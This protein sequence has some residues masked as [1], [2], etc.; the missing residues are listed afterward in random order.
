MRGHGIRLRII[1]HD[2]LCPISPNTRRARSGTHAR[3]YALAAAPRLLASLHCTN[4]NS[5]RRSTVRCATQHRRPETR[6]TH[7]VPAQPDSVARWPVIGF[8]RSTA[9]E[10]P[11]ADAKDGWRCSCPIRGNQHS[12]PRLSHAAAPVR[13]AAAVRPP[14]RSPPPPA[15]RQT[16]SRCPQARDHTAQLLSISAYCRESASGG[17]TPPN[18]QSCAQ[19]RK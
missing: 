11:S 4:D 1:L 14:A 5:V 15:R 19:K 12:H 10:Q 8:R 6:G 16:G 2:A 3:L 7:G 9:L 18:N 17:A 13:P